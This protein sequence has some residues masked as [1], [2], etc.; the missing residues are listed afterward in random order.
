VNGETPTVLPSYRR[1]VSHIVAFEGFTYATYRVLLTEIAV[2][3]PYVLP[4][5]VVNISKSQRS[6]AK[7]IYW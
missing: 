7:A 3:V 2:A 1:T 6:A 5:C 4:G